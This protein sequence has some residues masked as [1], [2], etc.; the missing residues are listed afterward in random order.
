MTFFHFCFFSIDISGSEII[1]ADSDN[2]VVTKTDTNILLENAPNEVKVHLNNGKL[3]D[4]F[5]SVF[6]FVGFF[7]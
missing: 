1:I 4:L 5:D 7:H 3:V 2:K 6:D